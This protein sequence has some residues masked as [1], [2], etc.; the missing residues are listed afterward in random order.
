MNSLTTLPVLASLRRTTPSKS[1][2]ATT[3]PS[4][5]NDTE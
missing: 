2:E 4:G 5:R 3:L 1:A